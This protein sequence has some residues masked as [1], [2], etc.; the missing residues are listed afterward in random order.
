M[1][2]YDVCIIGGGPMAWLVA[3]LSAAK[4]GLS[5]MIIEKG[6]IVNGLYHYPVNMTFFSTAERLEIGWC[7][8]Y[9][10]ACQTQP[11]RS[12]GVLPQGG[13]VICAEPPAFESL[14]TVE[15]TTD[16]LFQL[17]TSKSSYTANCIVVATGFL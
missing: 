5:Y 15:K 8:F 13:A 14:E 16:G 1:S 12:A 3:L 11:C 4:A 2:R 9:E 17:T 10:P 6:C 7:S